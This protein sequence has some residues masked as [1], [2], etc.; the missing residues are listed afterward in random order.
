MSFKKFNLDYLDI[1]FSDMQDGGGIVV[2][3]DPQHRLGKNKTWAVILTHDNKEAPPTA[4]GLFWDE[5]Q[6]ER[7]AECISLKARV[8]ELETQNEKLR[9][10]LVLMDH[11]WHHC[12][13]H[14]Q[15]RERCEDMQCC[16]NAIALFGKS[17]MS[18]PERKQYDNDLKQALEDL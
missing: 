14:V 15:Y 18:V 5:D 9:L 13:E 16:A 1:P 8:Q 3:K 6:A 11:L 7:F 2:C 10:R 4:L 12:N 17:S